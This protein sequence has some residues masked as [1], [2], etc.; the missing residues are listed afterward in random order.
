MAMGRLLI[1]AGV[2][3]V[4]VGL[5]FVVLERLHV[6]PGRLPGDI[7]LRAKNTTFYFPLIT[8]LVLSLLASLAM[9][10]LNRR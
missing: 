9:W 1:T 8:C 3:L 6:V 2:L 10:L 4:C 5:V 7:I